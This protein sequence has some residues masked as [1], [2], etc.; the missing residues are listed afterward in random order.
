MTGYAGSRDYVGNLQ[1][2]QRTPHRSTHPTHPKGS[3]SATRGSSAETARFLRNP[4]TRRTPLYV[5]LTLIV[6][7][8]GSE[9]V[10]EQRAVQVIVLSLSEEG[11]KFRLH[12]AL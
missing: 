3:E 4:E 8:L 7:P 9:L 10:Q 11:K 1:S 2:P 12:S 6:V 5:Y